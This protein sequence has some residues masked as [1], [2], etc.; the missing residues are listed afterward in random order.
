MMRTVQFLVVFN[1]VLGLQKAA[2]AQVSNAEAQANRDG[3]YWTSSGWMREGDSRVYRYSYS[4]WVL[5]DDEQTAQ[6]AAAGQRPV[7][8]ASQ[9]AGPRPIYLSGTPEAGQR[10]AEAQARV[11]LIVEERQ[12]RQRES[13]IAD[14]YLRDALR[15]YPMASQDQERNRYIQWRMNAADALEREKIRSG[16]SRQ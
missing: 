16:L 3:Y 8:P 11:R 14:K 9:R 2:V 13:E 12:R 1:C 5:A 6:P 15:F 4:R 7:Q 10:E